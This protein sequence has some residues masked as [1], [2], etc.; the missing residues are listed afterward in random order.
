MPCTMPSD[1]GLIQTQHDSFQRHEEL[2]KLIQD[3]DVFYVPVRGEFGEGPINN[4]NEIKRRF[5]EDLI[6]KKMTVVSIFGKNIVDGICIQF[7]GYFDSQITENVN[8]TGYEKD[9]NMM[10]VQRICGIGRVELDEQMYLKLSSTQTLPTST[11]AIDSED[12]HSEEISAK[13]IDVT[14]DSKDYKNK[15]SHV[16]NNLLGDDFPSRSMASTR[17]KTRSRTISE[18]VLTSGTSPT[19]TSF[20]HSRL[21][22]SNTG[23]HPPY[24]SPSTT[25]IRSSRVIRNLKTQTHRTPSPVPFGY[26][27]SS[28]SAMHFNVLNSPQQSV[29]M[30][31][32]SQ[33]QTTISSS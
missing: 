13:L 3:A 18:S 15:S 33:T 10:N 29:L 14:T 11:D 7:I 2:I 17:K 25:T 8:Q 24:P 32:V 12:M 21:H 26:S 4:I 30:P 23:G 6:N 28:S 5:D 22:S 19:T 20:D 31:P 16:K 9:L 27:P 1:L